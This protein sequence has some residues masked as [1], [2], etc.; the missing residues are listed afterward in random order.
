M[1][2]VVVLRHLGRQFAT[3]MTGVSMYLEKMGVSPDTL[4]IIQSGRH[5]IDFCSGEFGRRVMVDGHSMWTPIQ[6]RITTLGSLILTATAT[7]TAAYTDD[8]TYSRV[9]YF[10][11]H[12]RGVLGATQGL[13]NATADRAIVRP[14]QGTTWG[15]I[16]SPVLPPQ[17][18]WRPAFD[19]GV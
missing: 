4:E 9:W 7:L 8:K 3:T 17:A 18:S 16:S 19:G 12:L 13:P 1:G 6:S 14:A 10:V 11:P 15:G 2:S 5:L